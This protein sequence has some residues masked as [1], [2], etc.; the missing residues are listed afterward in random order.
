MSLSSK[1]AQH[2]HFKPYP[3][4]TEND[5]IN[6]ELEQ[7]IEAGRQIKLAILGNFVIGFLTIFIMWQGVPKNIL[8]GWIALLIIS[9]LLRVSI[10]LN[11]KKVT[12]ETLQQWKGHFIS[13]SLFSSAIWGIA[14]I[15]IEMYSDDSY[16]GVEAFILGGMAS[17]AIVTNTPIRYN[18]PA[19]MVPM[20]TLLSLYYFSVNDTPHLVMGVM[21]IIFMMILWTAAVNFRKLQ[22]E[23]HVLLKNTTDTLNE[24]QESEQRLK[25]ITTSMGEGVFVV[26]KAGNLTFINPEGERMLGWTFHEL[27]EDDEDIYSKIYKERESISDKSL[28]KISVEE[29]TILHSDQEVFKRKDGEIFP[30]SITAAPIHSKDESKEGVVVVFQDITLQKELENKLEKMALYDAL[31]GLYN[32]GSFTKALQDELKRADRYRKPISLLLIDIDFFKK[33]NDIYGHLAGD[34]VLK[35]VASMI[36]SSIR[37]SDYAA[38]YG[39][40]E[41]VVILPETNTED[42]IILAERIRVAIEEKEFKISMDVTIHLTVSIGIGST[43]LKQISPE[44]LIETADKALY[45]AKANGRNQV[46]Y[47]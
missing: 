22:F 3:N 7:V 11:Y 2:Q 19:F 46:Q 18:Y 44:Q 33:V 23:K 47:L 35:S 27:T 36:K 10:L 30:V 39:G 1:N 45:K 28:I 41:F 25:D 4:C 43:L 24:L 5:K 17:G 15:L 29:D 42:S 31:T 6:L 16:H 38:R 21:V 26:N 34:A 13:A 20:L 37:N 12:Y 40:E 14:A 32:R 8:A 9:I